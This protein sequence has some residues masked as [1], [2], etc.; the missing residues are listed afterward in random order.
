MMT[1]PP[2]YTPSKFPPCVGVRGLLCQET[3]TVDMPKDVGYELFK[4]PERVSS[5]QVSLKHLLTDD[6][7]KND[8]GFIRWS[9]IREA[10]HN[11]ILDVD[12]VVSLYR[13]WRD[14]SEYFLMDGFDV[15]GTYH[16]SA[17]G[18]CSKRGNDVYKHRVNE[19]FEVLDRLPSLNFSEVFPDNRT[20]MLFV[21]LTVDT[22]LYSLD[23]AWKNISDELHSFETKL[24]QEY[25]D[26]VKFR[27]WESH[28]SGYP[29]SHIAYYF[30]KRL[31]I[32]FPHKRKKDGVIVHRIPTKHRDKI[33]SFWGMS[34]N[35]NGVDVQAVVSTSGAM[36]EIKKYVTKS[37]FNEKGDKT[38]AML[39]LYRKQQYAISKDFVEVIWGDRSQGV[40]TDSLKNDSFSLLVKDTVHNCNKE[41]S[42]VCDF[43]Y[44]GVLSE[45]EMFFCDGFGEPPPIFDDKDYNIFRLFDLITEGSSVDSK[46][47]YS[48]VVRLV[49]EGFRFV[50]G[51][52]LLEEVEGSKVSLLC[53]WFSLVDNIIVDQQDIN[54]IGV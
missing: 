34:H 27:V 47:N 21:T 40:K 5:V 12:D 48:G 6:Y 52:K 18:K 3:F 9:L 50:H 44:S 45:T 51:L 20:P 4:C 19:K 28:K 22:K 8:K 32:T 35:V 17:Y 42:E 13:N 15:W 33:N 46:K 2:A 26:F 41:Y 24:R 39:C 36:S 1:S 7:F 49:D 37:I 25:G 23:E 43:R 10:Y 53:G 16:L 11:R 30:K 29:H 14:Q 38:N 31:F 54:R